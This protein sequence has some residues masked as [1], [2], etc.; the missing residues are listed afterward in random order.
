MYGGSEEGEFAFLMDYAETPLIK[1]G[2]INMWLEGTWYFGANGHIGI[3][4]GIGASGGN[5]KKKKPEWNFI[6]EMGLAFRFF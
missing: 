1:N 5:L 6:F 3:Y 2:S 4:G